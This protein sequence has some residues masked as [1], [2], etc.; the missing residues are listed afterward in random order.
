MHTDRERKRMKQRINILISED[1]AERLK[2]Y[3]WENHK[4]VSQA[5]TDRSWTAKVKNAQVRGQT[6]LADRMKKQETAAA[7]RCPGRPASEFFCDS[8]KNR[9]VTALQNRTVTAHEINNNINRGSLYLCSVVFLPL[10]LNPEDEF[11]TG[12][13]CDWTGKKVFSGKKSDIDHAMSW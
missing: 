13:E 4:T 9:I 8:K 11:W 7:G 2:M 12:E 6:T 1:T 10:G 3:A 5:I